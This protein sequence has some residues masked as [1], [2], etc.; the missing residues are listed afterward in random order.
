MPPAHSRMTLLEDNPD[1][2]ALAPRPRAKRNPARDP[3]DRSEAGLFDNRLGA[4]STVRT[5]PDC[6]RS[7]EALGNLGLSRL[8]LDDAPPGRL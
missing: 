5:A 1:H 6:E 8:G 2:E 7:D 3:D 4:N